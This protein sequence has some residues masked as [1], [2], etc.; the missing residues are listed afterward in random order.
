MQLGNGATVV[1][2]EAAVDLTADDQ[3]REV[4]LVAG[5]RVDDHPL[6]EPRLVDIGA[7]RAHPTG[8]VDALDARKVDR[9]TLPSDDGV[10]IVGGPVG[11][12]ARP[13]V[14]V[15]QRGGGHPHQRV[16]RSGRWARPII[17]HLDLVGAAVAERDRCGHR[18]GNGHPCTLADG[19]PSRSTASTEPSGPIVTTSEP[20]TSERTDTI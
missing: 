7:D 17:P 13:D 6:V 15:V 10:G 3:A 8:D 20:P 12:L 9:H 1:L 19:G 2:G 18:A 5:G 14:G 16:T 11:A 4:V